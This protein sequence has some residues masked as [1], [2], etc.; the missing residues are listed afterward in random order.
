[1]SGQV[2]L[3]WPALAFSL[4]D[5]FLLC[6]L[7]FTVLLEADR[8]ALGVWLSADGLFLGAA[9]FYCPYSNFTQRLAVEQPAGKFLVAGWLVAVDPVTVCLVLGHS[10]VFRL[11]G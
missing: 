9:F 10:L 5:A 3:D 11:L 7:G 6:W 2:L 8:R 1:M 4:F